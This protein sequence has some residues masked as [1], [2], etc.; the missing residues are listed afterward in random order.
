[1]IPKE[2]HGVTVKSINDYTFSNSTA[3]NIVIPS[4]VVYVGS[5]PDADHLK[6]VYFYGDCPTGL[7]STL[8]YT[9]YIEDTTIYCKETYRS[10]FEGLYGLNGDWED[11]EFIPKASIAA[12]LEDPSY[13]A[14]PN[15]S[16][17]YTDNGDG[18][19]SAACSDEGCTEVITNEAH[20]YTLGV[21]V[22]GAK[23]NGSDPSYFNYQVENGEAAITGYNK[24]GQGGEITLP[25]TYTDGSG[26]TYPVTS[27]AAR[28]FNGQN[29]AATSMNETD[30][31]ALSKITKITVPASITKVGDFAFNYVGR[32]HTRTW[33]LTEIVFEGQEVSF[34]RGVFG[35]NEK[36]TAVTL[37]TKMTEITS[38]MF[39]KD[40][41]LKT[42]ELPSSV[43]QV[44]ELAFSGCTA[45][46]SVTFK[47]V[48][49]PPWSRAPAIPPAAI[50]LPGSRRQ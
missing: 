3:T 1:M 18:T 36:L 7:D 25:S 37:P 34:G 40:T 44:G 27:V 16:W 30:A 12:D 2:I 4:T 33:N 21:C 43:A 8:Q 47:S 22:C 13:A 6:S 42:L 35:S 32:Y 24:N 39:D 49:P 38:R 5:L 17:V 10:S 26:T 28:A 20:T 29:G 48:T 45:L 19:H 11:E 23:V 41:A 31:E 50:P 15:H 46:E 9:Y 14:A